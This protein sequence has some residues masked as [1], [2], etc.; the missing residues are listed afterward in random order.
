MDY[1]IKVEKL[2]KNY[3]SYTAVDNLSFEVK[4]GTVFGLLG[5]NG[6]GKSTSIECILGTNIHI[7][8]VQNNITRSWMQGKSTLNKKKPRIAAYFAFPFINCLPS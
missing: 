1:A 8:F 3:Q 2:S 5:A 4:K 6:A 7:D